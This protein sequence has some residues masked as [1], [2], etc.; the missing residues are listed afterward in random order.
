M[1]DIS[2]SILKPLKLFIF[3][4]FL[5]APLFIGVSKIDIS[6]SAQQNNKLSI[7]SREQQH[8]TWISPSRNGLEVLKEF[9]KPETKYAAGHRGID[10]PALSGD[11]IFAPTTGRVTFSGLV[12][13][14]PLITFQTNQNLL[15]T[16]EPV[17]SEL[18]PGDSVQRGE[19][20]GNVGSGAHCNNICVHLGIRENGEY[21]NPL[22][23][24]IS[25]PELLPLINPS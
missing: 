6:V 10:F 9:K 4:L 21:I 12:V 1:T 13:D 25:K 16:L 23:F 14:R 7:N 3:H 24:F 17:I 5:F 19:L 18:K 15:V 2:I 8:P 11:H 20:L 22:R